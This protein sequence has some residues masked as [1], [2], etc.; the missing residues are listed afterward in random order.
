MVEDYDEYTDFEMN[1]CCLDYD[2]KSLVVTGWMA[3]ILKLAQKTYA[4]LRFKPD[5]VC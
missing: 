4:N 1:E 3:E 2:E 5:R